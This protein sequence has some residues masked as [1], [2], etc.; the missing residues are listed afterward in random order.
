MHGKETFDEA[1]KTEPVL[2]LIPHIG[3]WEFAAVVLGKPYSTHILFS[4][5]QLGALN[6][7]IRTNREEYG[8]TMYENTLVGLRGIVSALQ[9]GKVVAVLPDQVPTRGRSVCSYFF[10]QPAQTTTLV[11]SLVGRSKSR[12]KVFVASFLRLTDGIDVYFDLVDSGIADDDVEKSVLCMNRAIE[13]TVMRAP[14]Q[15]QWE[16][17]R[18]RRTG[19]VSIYD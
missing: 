12:V 10:G 4:A 9:P 7:F 8:L 5:R 18:F 14:A 6:E 16:Y 3:F 19:D 15:Y 11:H 1:L 2:L 13:A 17:K